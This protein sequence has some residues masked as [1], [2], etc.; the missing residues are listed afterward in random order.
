MT[1]QTCACGRKVIYV[2]KC[3]E[4]EV[5]CEIVNQGNDMQAIY[6]CSACFKSCES[7]LKEVK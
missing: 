6:T 3:C 1:P 7:F 2:S 4:A 5:E